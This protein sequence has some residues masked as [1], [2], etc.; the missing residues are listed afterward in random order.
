MTAAFTHF[1][2]IYSITNSNSESAFTIECKTSDLLA[3]A[4]IFSIV[5]GVITWVKGH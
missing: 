5:I 1:F 3:E 2:I 4:L